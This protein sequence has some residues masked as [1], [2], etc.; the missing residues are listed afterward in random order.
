M[1]GLGTGFCAGL[2]NG[3]LATRFAIPMIAVTIGGIS[4]FRGIAYAA[5]GDQAFTKHPSSFSYLGQGSP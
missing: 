2:R 3:I 5:L 1:A 4:L